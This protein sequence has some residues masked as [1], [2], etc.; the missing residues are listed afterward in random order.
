MSKREITTGWNDNDYL[1][2]TRHAAER[3]LERAKVR[4]NDFSEA[5]F[6]DVRYG[7]RFEN[8]KSNTLVYCREL[9]LLGPREGKTLVTVVQVDSDE[10][11]FKDGKYYRKQKQNKSS[12]SSSVELSDAV[13]KDLRDRQYE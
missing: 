8:F 9:E 3:A 7:D 13:R 6:R 12:S 10:V 5:T 11:G 2:V 4:K 1:N